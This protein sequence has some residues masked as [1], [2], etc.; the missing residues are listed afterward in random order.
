MGIT[1]NPVQL[2]N[3]KNH[4]VATHTDAD[5]TVIFTNVFTSHESVSTLARHDER[6]A[7]LVYRSGYFTVKPDTGKYKAFETV[8]SLSDT[9]AD[10]NRNYKFDPD[11]KKEAYVIGAVAE[12]KRPP[13]AAKDPKDPGKKDDRKGR[14]VAFADA[15]SISDGLLSNSQGNAV[16]IADSLKWLVGKAELQGQIADEE[17]VKIRHTRKEDL[18]WFHSTVVV[19]PLLVLGAGFLATR[20][21]KTNAKE[22]VGTDAA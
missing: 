10:K 6:V 18:I 3:E 4:L 5:N 12:Q 7:L 2:A 8:R 20:R 16:F 22:K 13:D 9:F 19:V 15:A 21:K 11:E 17:D 14:V 1:Y